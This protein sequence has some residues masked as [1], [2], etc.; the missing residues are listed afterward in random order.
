[1][2]ITMNEPAALK[3]MVCHGPVRIS[4]TKKGNGLYLVCQKDGRHYRAFVM[5]EEYVQGVIRR[6]EDLDS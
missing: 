1:M 6:A 2:T 3:C 5:D 4:L